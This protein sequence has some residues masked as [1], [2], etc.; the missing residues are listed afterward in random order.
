MQDPLHIRNRV[1]DRLHSQS[2][3]SAAQGAF[4]VINAMQGLESPASQ[5]IALACAY[6]NTCAVMGIDPAEAQRV[7]ERMERDC[8][9]RE[10]NTLSAVRKYVERELLPHFP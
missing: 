3:D 9:Y 4:E 5:V 7:V 8:R 2:A 6:R 1:L 10:V